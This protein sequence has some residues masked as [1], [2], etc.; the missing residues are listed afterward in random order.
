MDNIRET[1]ATPQQLKNQLRVHLL[2]GSHQALTD[3]P[4]RS[5]LPKNSKTTTHIIHDIVNYLPKSRMLP[6]SSKTLVEKVFE[7][8]K[9][10]TQEG[11]HTTKK[12]PEVL[13]HSTKRNLRI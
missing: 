4:V 1:P 2:P 11:Q 9:D 7:T 8:A 5:I 13:E 6:V 10:E 3:N 12:S